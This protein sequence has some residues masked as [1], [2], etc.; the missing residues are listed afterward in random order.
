[1]VK[2]LNFQKELSG[3]WFVDL[4]EWPGNKEDLE[5][6]MGADAMLDYMCCGEPE[7]ALFLSTDMIENHKFGPPK[8]VLDFKE[9]IYE[10]ATYNLSGT[11][12]ELEVWLCHVTKFVFGNFPHKIFIY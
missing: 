5:M 7:V 11:G 8:Y 1:M 10:G 9:E 6:V 12:I 4:P 3:K 2:L